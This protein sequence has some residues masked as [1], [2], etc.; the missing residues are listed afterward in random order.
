MQ[1]NFPPFSFLVRGKVAGFTI[2]YLHLL[3]ENTKITFT[4]VPGTWEEN[5]T[6]FT[7][8]EVDAIT[9]IS[10]TPEREAFTR[11]TTPYYLI[12]TVVYIRE[13]SFS[14]N[15]VETLK[16][17]DV[18]ME[19]GIYYKDYLQAYPD[20]R[21]MEI[22]DTSELMK[23]LS[24]GEIDAVVTNINIG[25]FMIKQ[26]VLENIRLAGKIDI[27]AIENEDLR[28]GVRKD[29]QQV[30]ALLQAAMN[31]I[32][33]TEYRQLQDRWIGGMPQNMQETLMPGDRELINAH[34]KQHGGFRLSFHK[35]WYP[36]DFTDDQNAHAGIAAQIFEMVAR[37]HGIRLVEQISGSLEEAVD[38][39][40]K[41]ESDILPAIVPSAR[42]NTKLIFTRP[43]LSLPLVI[44]TSSEEFFVGDLKGLSEK[45][46]GLVDRGGL[47]VHFRKT[48]PDL[49]FETMR[50]AR[51]GLKHVQNKK[52]FAF[53][54]TIPSIAYAVK[55]NN[56][57]NIKISGKLEETLPVSAAVHSE[58]QALAT[59]LDKILQNISV[60]DKEKIVDRWI[61]ISLEEKVDYTLVWQVSIGLGLVLAAAVFWLKK[62]QGFN[63]R[64]SRAYALL[65]EKNLELEQ[66]SITDSLTGLYNRH[67]LD[68][69]LVREK[70]RSDRY[71]HVFSLV[72]LDIDHFKSINDRFG[73]QAGDE[74][75][76]QVGALI[77]KSIRSSDIPGRWGGE[78]FL[79]ICPETNRQGAKIFAEK[80]RKD[81][82]A[83]SFV[84]D[85]TI[86]IS[87][88]V[89]E[90]ELKEDSE[91]LVKRADDNLYK[92]KLSG[93]NRIC[94]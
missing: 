65:E 71:N 64:I 45:R 68:M 84:S 72:I 89:A 82:Q 57:Y 21:I 27:P 14:Y 38:A 48:Y 81:L 46:I 7:N 80:I 32:P 88:G 52:L 49:V 83:V 78:E 31:S 58:N 12:P 39:V 55:N 13:N 91:K 93:R 66:F 33:Y 8:G 2:D 23:K 60:E 34:A 63:R 59:V 22:D 37:T 1:N 29:R 85:T 6:R 73:H 41:K 26:H 53:V 62:V 75:L 15:G 50:S 92:A 40:F 43:Y 4:F 17:R 74:V 51:E 76:R 56:Y 20:I 3:S 19:T 35:N 9:E 94:V 61:S 47:A 25:N 86:T 67:K 16:E 77:K 24:F 28:I 70:E 90:Y 54:D 44:A 36:V 69:H 42:F 10:H 5:L 18:G 79:I 87:G 30:H 11:F